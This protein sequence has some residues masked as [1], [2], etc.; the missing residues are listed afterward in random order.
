MDGR[1][2]IRNVVGPAAATGA[3]PIHVLMNLPAIA[4]EFLDAFAG[5]LTNVPV[6]IHCHCFAPIDEAEARRVTL[7]RVRTSLGV[8]V[9]NAEIHVVRRVAPNKDMLCVT[10]RLPTK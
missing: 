6:T 9:V 2:F 5:M 7:E 8:Q 10:F 3:N 4:I 1:E